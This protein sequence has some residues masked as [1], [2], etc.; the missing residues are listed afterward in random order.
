MGVGVVSELV[1][2]TDGNFEQTILKGDKPAIVD[3][4]AEWCHPC[5]VLEPS[6]AAVAKEYEGRI[7]VGK[8]DVDESRLVAQQF[9]IMS[10]PTVIFV[11][12][13]KE[14]HRFVGVQSKETIAD[15]IKSHLL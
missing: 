1:H 13:G 5:K 2:V 11:K 15:L 3:I 7:T 14:V 10:V 8:L 12:D 4:G 6:I 9:G